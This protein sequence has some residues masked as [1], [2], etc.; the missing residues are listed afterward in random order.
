M[1]GRTVKVVWTGSHLV[2]RVVAGYAWG[3]ENDWRCEVAGADVAVVLGADS[4]LVADVQPDPVEPE[5][6]A[7]DGA[8]VPDGAADA[9]D[10]IEPE[11]E[12]V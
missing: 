8:E 4:A 1:S 2:R 11:D 7:G 5:S 9:P 3:P 12:E 10:V 6:V